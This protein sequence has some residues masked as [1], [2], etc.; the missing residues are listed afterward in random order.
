MVHGLQE[1]Q[2]FIT[3]LR[4]LRAGYGRAHE[5]FDVCVWSVA[6][7]VDAFRRLEDAGVSAVLT[8]P[9]FSYPG[10][11]TSLDHKRRSLERFAMD[12]L[13]KMR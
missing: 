1:I 6:S 10:D 7:D 8:V 12:V 4:V 9:W 13:A 3:R 11:P 2:E 5:P